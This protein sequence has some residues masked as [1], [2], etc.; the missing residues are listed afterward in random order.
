MTIYKRGDIILVPFPFS[1]QTD[2]KKRPAAV[3]S[4]D[5]YNSVS[6]DIIIIAI[7][8]RVN[9]IISPEECLIEDWESAGLLKPSAI[10]AAIST[11]DAKLVLRKLGTLSHRDTISMELI[12]NV[13]F[14]LS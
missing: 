3:I 8:S 2:A 7:T 4:S 6:S 10:K 1:N 11:I 12:L 9:E 5:A 13:L 14:D